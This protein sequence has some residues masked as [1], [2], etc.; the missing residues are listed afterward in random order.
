MLLGLR[1]FSNTGG[2]G[3]LSITGY[4]PNGVAIIMGMAAQV[5]IGF[6]IDYTYRKIWKRVTF[7]VMSLLLL[8]AMIYTGSRGGILAFMTGVAVYA[9]PYR[10]SK[11]KMLAILGVSIV[12]IGVIYVVLNDQS[13]ASR[14]ENSYK[15]GDTAGRNYIFAAAVEMFSEKPLLGWGPMTLFE[16]GTRTRAWLRDTHNLFLYLLAANGLLGT[17]PFLIGLGLCVR[18]A[19]IA[20]VCSLGLLPLVWLVT[21]M[22]ASIS[23][24]WIWSKLLWLALALSLASEAYIVKQHMRKNLIG[25]IILQLSQKRN[26]VHRSA[27]PLGGP[28]AGSVSLY[29]RFSRA[30]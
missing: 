10:R 23:S 9:L 12:V 1:G 24:T 30:L 16:L 11:R 28:Q 8:T 27:E 21:M 14:L 26:S 18:A 20:R 22:V 4:N 25:R 19:W 17:I 6:G 5:L 7:L 29:G 15:Y 13:T 3:R 2:E